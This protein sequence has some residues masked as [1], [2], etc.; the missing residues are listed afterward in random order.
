VDFAHQR[1]V[2]HRDLKP[3]NVLVTSDAS[4]L[5][6][7]ITDFGLA[8]FLAQK[9]SQHTKSYAFLGTPS[10][11]APEQ[12]RGGARE[13]GPA[14][15]IYSLGAILYELLTGQ[16][17][18]RGE[19]PVE[20]LRLLLSSDPISI[21][22]LAPRTP[23]D[24]ATICEKCLQTDPARRYPSAAQ[25]REDLTRYLDGRPIQARPVGNLERARRWCRRNPLLAAAFGSVAVLLLGIAVMSLWYSAQLSDELERTRQVEQAERA[26]N[27]SAQRRL[28]DS[29][30]TEAAARNGGR[31][32][33]RRFAALESIDKAAALLPTIGRSE[34]RELQLRN[35]IL[36]SAALPDVRVLREFALSPLNAYGVALSLRQNFC[37]VTA[38]DH[39]IAGFRLSDGKRLWTIEHSEPLTTPI[40]S[41]DGRLLAAIGKRSL[42]VWQL[43]ETEP[44]PA[45]EV[46]GVQF[47]T[48]SPRG[49]FAAYG[50]KEAMQLV[51]AASGEIVRTLGS[52]PSES[53]IAFDPRTGRI[54]VGTEKGVTVISLES[55]AIDFELSIDVQFAPVVAWHPGGKYMA[56]WQ[57]FRGIGIWDI[58][59]RTK[60]FDLAHRGVPAKLTFNDD[61]SILVTETLWDRRMLAWDVGNGQPLLEVPDFTSRACEPAANGHLVF[62]AVNDDKVA[63]SELSLGARLSFSQSFDPPVGHWSKVSISPESR[64]V[65]FSGDQGVE[66]WDLKTRSRLFAQALGSTRA[67]FNSAGDLFLGF[68]SAI[69]RLPRQ[70]EVVSAAAGEEQP[71]SIVG[72]TVVRYGPPE[73][74]AST[75]MPT[76]FQITADGQSL[77][78]LNQSR[79]FALQ[80]NR[81]SEALSLQHEGD[82]RMAA[83]SNDNRFVVLANWEMPGATVLDAHS[84]EKITNLPVGRHGAVQ[85]SPD[86][87]FLAATPNGVTLWHAED[88]RQIANLHASG[89]T[90]AGLGIVF[91]PD[92]RVLA[93]GQVNGVLSFVDP[94]TG[95]E[96]V[97][98]LHH[99]L[100]VASHLAFSSDQ[101][102]LVTTPEDERSPSQ[103]WDLT[104][105][106]RDLQK[107]NLDWPA[108][109]LCVLANPGELNGDVEVV[110]DDRGLFD[111]PTDHRGPSSSQ[112]ECG[113]T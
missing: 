111:R 74:L 55:G 16:P 50:T 64:L 31:Q 80:S 45:W 92:S 27:L 1:Q 82:A 58:G 75:L 48:F 30:L 94:R 47:L 97:H 71:R 63:I 89:T 26:A 106:R 88:W 43:D 2:I 14:T 66:L 22:Q 93:V 56:I 6:V 72:R 95:T 44:R 53:P 40:V 11:M 8:K 61:G 25:L 20:T 112:E 41:P 83:L 105:L 51:R 54:A 7:K 29:Y 62:A 52:G 103:V 79:R 109:V 78:Y 73:R 5:E 59:K 99:E 18:F 68:G 13:V 32:V 37:V 108:D 96:L 102:W 19:T 113:E 12:A 90:P 98:I 81:S 65:A 87:Q 49:E 77:L 34:D 21:F 76:L 4:E 3:A 23:R 38:H 35:A 15:D 9:S 10:Y 100:R 17:P 46:E 24:L 70:L 36:S 91:S 85:F 107:R 84:A 42:T 39:S 110:I 101:R 33:G 104:A 86:G 28:W 67:A 57:N 60:V 69:Y